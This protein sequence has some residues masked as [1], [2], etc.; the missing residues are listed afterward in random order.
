MSF[1]QKYELLELKADQNGVKSFTASEKATGRMISAHILV[2]VP[3]AEIAAI[4]SR[5]YRQL[6]G[7]VI[8]TGEHQGTPYVVTPLWQRPQGF[9]EWIHTL[10]T[11][12]NMPAANE[13]NK[14][15]SWR[16]PTAE[17]TKK[18]DLGRRRG[19]RTWRS[20]LR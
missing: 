13:I 10:P 14:A 3:P 20:T 16:V 7:E 4:L 17:F 6:G 1:Y 2:G 15:G 12:S 5:A 11:G 9:V 18:S 19:N 8:E